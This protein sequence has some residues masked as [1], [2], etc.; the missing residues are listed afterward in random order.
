MVEQRELR[1][2][3]MTWEAEGVLSVRL[4][5]IDNHD[6]LPA[7]APGAHIDVYVPDG[8][9]RQYSLCGDPADR[10]SW[11]I[12][13]LREPESTGGSSF[14]HETLRVGD[15]LL[16]T[17]P[18]NH[19]VLE[20]APHH[21]LIAG[22]IG[23]TPMMAMAEELARRDTPYSL[24][25]GGRT[26]SSMAFIE[27]LS[28]LG[29]R[30]TLLAEDADGRPD[31]DALVRNTPAGGLVYVCGPLPLLR[32]VEAAAEAVH[33]PDQDV[34]RFELFS[35]DG[36]ERHEDPVADLDGS[37]YELVLAASGHTLRLP[38]DATILDVV[39]ALGIE[40]E[41]DCRDGI[42]G[43]CLTP[44]LDGTVEHR[45]LVLTKREQAAMDQMLI[46]CSRPT[47]PRLE[48]DL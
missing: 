19:F 45:D 22:G 24:T 33:G 42:C 39:L 48:L 17:R 36:V 14:V 3:R 5:R 7:W 16:V 41:N 11:Q 25:Y 20:D 8:T 4:G 23:I 27:R 32:A 38:P 1:V 46:C 10:S 44:V 9:T 18:K 31:V 28:V 35:T 21:T 13:V 43:S 15:R 47:S 40:V 30:L 29:E 26:A 6:P 2:T 12:A 34:V 37:T